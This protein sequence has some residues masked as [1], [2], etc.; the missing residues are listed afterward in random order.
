MGVFSCTTRRHWTLPEGCTV[1]LE[2]S[3]FWWWAL[4]RPTPPTKKKRSH[5]DGRT[6]ACF[7]S[8]KAYPIWGSHTTPP[9]A[10]HHGAFRNTMVHHCLSALVLLPGAFR[11]IIGTLWVDVNATG[12]ESSVFSSVRNCFTHWGCRAARKWL[13]SA[14]R[15]SVQSVS[16]SFVCSVLP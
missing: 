9:E 11:F 4:L 14:G 15:V 5:L 12:C 10:P 1:V 3:L 16:P 2:D 7:L 6:F 13:F 8:A